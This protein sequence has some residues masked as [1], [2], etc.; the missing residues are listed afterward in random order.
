MNRPVLASLMALALPILTCA[1]LTHALSRPKPRL[2]DRFLLAS[3]A[4]AV[5][6]RSPRRRSGI[7]AP[8][9]SSF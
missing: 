2:N 5:W 9:R 4:L 6:E 3:L 1:A 7:S 8:A